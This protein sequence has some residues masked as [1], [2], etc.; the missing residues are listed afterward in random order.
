VKWSRLVD[1]HGHLD[2]LSASWH[3]LG[4]DIII[5]GCSYVPDVPFRLKD[6]I[7]RDDEDSAS[8]QQLSQP[9]LSTP[10]GLQVIED[11]EQFL[12]SRPTLEEH[13]STIASEIDL[14]KEWIGSN[15]ALTRTIATSR[16]DDDHAESST[17]PTPHKRRLTTVETCDHATRY[18]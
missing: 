2:E 6:W 18:L 17:A 4:H 1:E 16:R 14:T 7:L 3:D 13:L 9:V 8:P 15:R 5:R 10:T 11:V 12:R